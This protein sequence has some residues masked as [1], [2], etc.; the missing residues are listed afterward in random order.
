MEGLNHFQY[1]ADLAAAEYIITAKR[2]KTAEKRIELWRNQQKHM[3]MERGCDQPVVGKQIFLHCSRHLD[4]QET[5]WLKE[6]VEQRGFEAVHSGPLGKAFLPLEI[7]AAQENSARKEIVLSDAFKL[8]ESF[9]EERR[10]RRELL[11]QPLLRRLVLYEAEL[12][13]VDTA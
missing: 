12:F 5:R 2:I 4:D 6:N 10:L 9:W 11:P 1:L 3:C 7:A 13:D 8:S